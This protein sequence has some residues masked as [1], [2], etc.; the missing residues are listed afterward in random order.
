MN[1]EFISVNP[2]SVIDESQ[3][4]KFAG[5]RELKTDNMGVWMSYPVVV[6]EYAGE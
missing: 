2:E 6:Y 3:K 5:F 1:T 4:L